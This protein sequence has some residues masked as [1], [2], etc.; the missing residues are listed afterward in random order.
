M[1]L[2]LNDCQSEVHSALQYDGSQDQNDYIAIKAS[3]IKIN[4]MDR[5]QLQNSV[6]RNY[7]DNNIN[8]EKLIRENYIYVLLKLNICSH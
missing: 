8:Q 2:Y 6:S 1:L 3:K 7:D 5:G 4:K